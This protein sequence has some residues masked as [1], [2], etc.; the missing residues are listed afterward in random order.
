M[1]LRLPQAPNAGLFKQGYSSQ[2][3]ADGA[4]NRNI[5]ACREISQMVLTSIGP[6]GRNKVIVNRMY[7]AVINNSGLFHF[8]S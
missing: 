6:C 2:S 7:Q 3:N 8:I 5:A 4:V 1:S